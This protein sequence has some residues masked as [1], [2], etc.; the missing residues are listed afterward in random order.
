[1][2]FNPL[3]LRLLRRSLE[4]EMLTTERRPES[5][6]S[7]PHGVDCYDLPAAALNWKEGEV[8]GWDM[9]DKVARV[10]GTKAGLIAVGRCLGSRDL[11]DVAAGAERIRVR[12]DVFEFAQ[13]GTIAADQSLIP[14]FWNE[15]LN[16]CS[17]NDGGGAYAFLGFLVKALNTST[18][19]V[20]VRPHNQLSG[21]GAP[22]VFRKTITHADLTALATSQLITLGVLPSVARFRAG[23][24]KLNTAFSGGSATEVKLSIGGTDDDGLIAV[25]DIFTGASTAETF[26]PLG[27]QAAACLAAQLGGQTIAAKFTSDVNVEA[28]TA[29]SVT[30]TLIFD[31]LP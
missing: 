5:A 12:G 15:T 17:A 7:L 13:D 9:T 18:C 8:V 19:E 21:G 26:T 4:P 31:P 11:R 24:I 16:K 29:G 3:P 22:I 23:S 10:L 14:V 30:I 1:M 2:A 20:D 27:V 6:A 25:R 28:L